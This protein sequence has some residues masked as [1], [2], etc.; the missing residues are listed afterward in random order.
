MMRENLNRIV[1]YMKSS[2]KVVHKDLPENIG[3]EFD[4]TCNEC[5][6]VCPSRIGL[7]KIKIT[8]EAREMS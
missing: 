7:K 3:M 5:V 2:R 4:L 1:L 8:K 6:H